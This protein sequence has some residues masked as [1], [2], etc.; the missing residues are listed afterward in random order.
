MVACICVRHQANSIGEP[1]TSL[2]LPAGGRD[3]VTEVATGSHCRDVA[4]STNTVCR[5]SFIA[6]VRYVAYDALT[7]E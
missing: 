1:V 3:R 4:Y 5:A 2:S 7:W 6:P